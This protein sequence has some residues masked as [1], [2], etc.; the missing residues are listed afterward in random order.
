MFYVLA[1]ASASGVAVKKIL[2]A[3]SIYLWPFGVLEIHA[4]TEQ[5]LS[6]INC[7]KYD[8]MVSKLGL[9]R[10]IGSFIF[11]PMYMKPAICSF[12]GSPPNVLSIF[13]L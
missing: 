6:Q 12:P 1:K 3:P 2:I 8:T 13:W 10:S 11:S 9:V 5:L 7:Y 4:F